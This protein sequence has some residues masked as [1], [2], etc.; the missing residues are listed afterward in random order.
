[1]LAQPTDPFATLLQR[2]V[3]QRNALLFSPQSTLSDI[4]NLQTQYREL[5][6]A[7]SPNGI[8]LAQFADA[9]REGLFDTPSVRPAALAQL[10]R[11]PEQSSALEQAVRVR[12]YAPL[13]ASDVSLAQQRV[14][15]TTLLNSPELPIL[16]QTEQATTVWDALLHVEPIAL[17]QEQESALARLPFLIQPQA[18]P[19]N[20][21]LATDLWR[22]GIL[23]ARAVKTPELRRSALQRLVVVGKE[24]QAVASQIPL[25]ARQQTS[26]RQQTERLESLLQLSKDPNGKILGTPLTFFPIPLFATGSEEGFWALLRTAS[27]LGTPT[28]VSSALLRPPPDSIGGS[29][30]K[31]LRETVIQRDAGYVAPFPALQSRFW[32]PI[33]LDDPSGKIT[34]QEFALS[35]E[36]DQVLLRSA[37][38]SLGGY[39]ASLGEL[40]WNKGNLTASDFRMSATLRERP[41]VSISSPAITRTG[42][43][44]IRLKDVRLSLWG[45]RLL[46][47]RSFSLPPISLQSLNAGESETEANTSDSPTP[48]GKSPVTQWLVF[49]FVGFVEGGVSV[50][51]RNAIKFGGRWTV[52]FSFRTYTISPTYREIGL[53]YNLTEIRDSPDRLF[54]TVELQQRYSGSYFFNVRNFG[55]FDENTYLFRRTAIAGVNAIYNDFYIDEEGNRRRVNIPFS[56]GT[57]VSAPLF[58]W[59]GFRGKA[60]YE[61][62]VEPDLPSRPRFSVLGTAGFPIVRLFRGVHAFS[63]LETGFR[64]YRNNRYEW[65]RGIVGATALILPTWRMSAAYILSRESGTPQ[66]PFDRVPSDEGISV[67]SD[68]NVGSFRLAYINQYSSRRQ[69]W[70]RWQAYVGIEVGVLEPY[71]SADQRF[72]SISAGVVFRLDPYLNR[73]TQ[74]QIQ[75]RKPESP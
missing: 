59:L 29:G 10:E 52:P 7:S 72:N 20:A 26:I 22:M 45:T 6:Q 18:H 66:Y 54:D 47:L 8:S 62:V 32:K 58:G 11:Y 48:Q 5:L 2:Y 41:V 42:D 35:P 55:V 24:A 43:S 53:N 65:Y 56:L 57:Q 44:P 27:A 21:L 15:L 46:T 12:L 19:K 70:E 74:R 14:P 16:L 63:R 23:I 75:P 13:S 67:R 69:Q 28:R 3:Q 36:T 73:F 9:V 1:M 34:A 68:L 4:Q 51:Y 64:F 60:V 39:R 50:G 37:N 49:P 33:T 25:S 30:G 71:I 40:F 61:E 31:E 38:L 17:L